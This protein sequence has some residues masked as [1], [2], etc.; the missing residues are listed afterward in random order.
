WNTHSAGQAWESPL[1]ESRA[2]KLP[3]KSARTRLSSYRGCRRRQ[4]SHRPRG[5]IRFDL[6]RDRR[7][8]QARPSGSWLAEQLPLIL[9]NSA[10]GYPPLWAASKVQASCLAS[11]LDLAAESQ[12]RNNFASPRRQAWQP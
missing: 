12:Y 2:I 1:R 9:K 11:A 3:A 5:D 7:F 10:E 8:D 4:E 6:D